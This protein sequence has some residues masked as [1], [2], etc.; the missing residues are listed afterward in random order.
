MIAG[1]RSATATVRPSGLMATA[2]IGSVCRM[3]PVRAPLI[4]S[5]NRTVLSELAEIAVRPSGA[6]ATPFPELVCSEKLSAG[7]GTVGFE[8]A[9][10]RAARLE[11]TTADRIQATVEIG[12]TDTFV[13]S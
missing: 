13:I 12:R 11:A 8:P 6:K 10:T 7:L 2:C 3:M 9:L 5:Q 4:K 1:E